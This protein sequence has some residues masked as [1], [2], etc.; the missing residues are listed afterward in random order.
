MKEAGAKE[1]IVVTVGPAK[2]SETLRTA[3]AMGVDRGQACAEADGVRERWESREWEPPPEGRD[4][5]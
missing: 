3:L 1:I 5:R 4:Q 2:S